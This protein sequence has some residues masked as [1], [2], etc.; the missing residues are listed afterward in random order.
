MNFN[1]N[2]EKKGMTFS[3]QDV[4]DEVLADEALRL[5]NINTLEFSKIAVV[6]MKMEV[7]LDS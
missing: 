5:G 6:L 4:T 2:N 3:L 7:Y 1:E